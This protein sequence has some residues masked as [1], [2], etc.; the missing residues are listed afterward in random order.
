[1][2]WS[3]LMSIVLKFCDPKGMNRLYQCQGSGILLKLHH[4]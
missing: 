3:H 4:N 1:M 2:T